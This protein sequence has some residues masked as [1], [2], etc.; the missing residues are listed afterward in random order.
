MLIEARQQ[1]ILELLHRK[2]SVTV[3]EL[4]EGLFVSPA[5][6]RRDLAAMEKLGLIKRSHGG[7]VLF[8]TGNS[9]I[10]SLV[11]EQ[12]NIQKKRRIARL[13]LDF[14]R[15]DCSVFLDSSSSAGALIPMLKSIPCTVITNG[16]NNA[17]LLS[18]NTS[19]RIYLAGGTVNSRSSAAVG[20]EAVR[21]VERFNTDLAILSCGGISVERGVM[22][23]SAEQAAIKRAMLRHA[24]VR[25]LLCDSSK[26]GTELLCRTCRFDQLD[27]LLTDCNPG[28][29]YSQAAGGAG[30]EILWAAP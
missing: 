30:C 20:A 24:K 17:L 29:A 7:A 16:L 13:A 25:V 26:F 2:K 9:E 14:F 11:R 28:A 3:R 6:V 4:S 12:E 8:E 21:Q 1:K 23:A 10:S 15:P 22:D 27:Y 5:T 19:A 18:R